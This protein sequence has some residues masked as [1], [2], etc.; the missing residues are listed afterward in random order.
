MRTPTAR[1]TL[2]ERI[3]GSNFAH[4]LVPL[5]LATQLIS[6]KVHKRDGPSTR[7]TGIAHTIAALAPLYTHNGDGSEIRRLTDQELLSGRFRKDGAELHFTDGRPPIINI[8]ATEKAIEDVAGILA[9][10]VDDEDRHQA[11]VSPSL[12]PM[13]GST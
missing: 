2:T 8:A 11:A 5:G 1:L 7:L 9:S 4:K 12:L 13:P 3:N 10:T 6:S